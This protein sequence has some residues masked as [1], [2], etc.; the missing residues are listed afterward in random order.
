MGS[1]FD[2]HISRY[3]DIF[4]VS[5]AQDPIDHIEEKLKQKACKNTVKDF[6]Q[7]CNID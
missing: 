3:W 7:I 4:K 6:N 1:D 2:I 5:E